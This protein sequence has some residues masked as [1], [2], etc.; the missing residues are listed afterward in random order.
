MEIWRDV[1][2]FE[3][4][5]QVSNKGRVRSFDKVTEDEFMHKSGIVV[6]RKRHYKGKIL[7]LSKKHSGDKYY[8]T[9]ML[10]Y[11]DWNRGR[12]YYVHRLVAEAFIPNP[13]NYP[14]INHKDENPSNNSVDN[15]EWCTYKYNTNYGTAIERR[16][17]KQ[18]NGEKS[19]PCAMYS[20]DGELLEKFD[21]CSEVERRYKKFK[22]SSVARCCKG[23]HYLKGKWQPVYTYKGYIFKFL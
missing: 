22:K 15:L 3:G 14:I 2:G 8:L 6:K 7:N 20:L 23:G 16:S 5:Y 4:L 11:K 21:S 19:K 10:N 13:N 1:V 9:V 17:K 12:R 18:I